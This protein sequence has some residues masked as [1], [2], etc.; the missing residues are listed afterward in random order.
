VLNNNLVSK[1]AISDFQKL[2]VNI[3]SLS[4][5]VSFDIPCSLNISFMKTWAISIAL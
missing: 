3:L 2:E 5:M 1:P 4:D